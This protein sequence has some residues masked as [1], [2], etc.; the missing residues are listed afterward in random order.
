MRRA[1]IVSL[2]LAFRFEPQRHSLVHRPTTRKTVKAGAPVLGGLFNERASLCQNPQTASTHWKLAYE[3]RLA[4]LSS[5][6]RLYKYGL[7]TFGLVLLF[8]A[9]FAGAAVQVTAQGVDAEAQARVAELIQ[10]VLG[11]YRAESTLTNGAA[12]NSLAAYKNIEAS[13][14]EAS[15]IMPDRL[16]LRFGIA[17]ALI[18]QA[19]QTNAPFDLT[20]KNALTVYREIHALDT[21][22]FQAGIL[23]AA[24]ARA[25]GD[26]H[27]SESLL[28]ELR[29]GHPEKVRAYREKFRRIDDAQGIIL[30]TE[31]PKA[32]HPNGTNAIVILGAGLETNGMMKPKLLGRLQQGLLLAR[33]YPDAP[34]IVTGGNQRAGVTEA[35][36]MGAWLEKQGVRTNR[37]HLEDRATDTVGNAIRSCAI[38]QKLGVTHITLVTSRSH[39]R[40]ALAIFEE[41]AV[42]REFSLQISHLV[43]ID[44]SEIDAARERV[45]LYRDV[46][47]TSG[48]WAY[49]GF[50]R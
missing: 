45:A 25:V 12:S 16:D 23:H 3:A 47:R 29:I 4:F 15:R 8:L 30:D 10:N 38:L 18:G 6:F 27:A 46:M 28:A 26:A 24:Y 11:S 19:L 2:R 34:I 20:I 22:G 7:G 36:V 33:F 44:E 41:A 49:P 43:S 37:L 13:F 39:L 35:Y 40:R 14:R 32:R 17:S 48:L 9:A 21:N 31:L 50:Q 1:S 42:N 5:V